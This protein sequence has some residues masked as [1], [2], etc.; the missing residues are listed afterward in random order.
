M[1]SDFHPHIF[2][3]VLWPH[4]LWAD[5]VA[6]H[7]YWSTRSQ[8]TQLTC[9]LFMHRIKWLYSLVSEGNIVSTAVFLHLTIL[10]VV[11]YKK[12]PW[13]LHSRFLHFLTENQWAAALPTLHKEQQ[14]IMRTQIRIR[15][16]GFEELGRPLLRMGQCYHGLSL[17][18]MSMVMGHGQHQSQISQMVCLFVCFSPPTKGF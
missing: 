12:K 9:W 10:R 7:A 2:A 5:I 3:F 1:L 4:W 14:P 11:K 16:L 17:Y 8:K 13:F 6:V 15:H 18:V